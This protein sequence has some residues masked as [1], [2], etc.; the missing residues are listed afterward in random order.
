MSGHHPPA[1]QGRR[2]SPGNGTA[3][4]DELSVKPE[5]GL[6]ARVQFLATE[7][8][9]EATANQPHARDLAASAL[10]QIRAFVGPA[11]DLAGGDATSS[12][13]AGG[14]QH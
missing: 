2:R 5:S 1:R 10:R 7:A 13:A 8:E 14:V 4:R 12:G 9:C 3:G 6:A 11:F